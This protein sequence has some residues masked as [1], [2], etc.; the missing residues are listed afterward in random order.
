MAGAPWCQVE[1]LQAP[2][3]VQWCEQL[4]EE[5]MLV[6]YDVRGAGMSDQE[7]DDH[8]LNAQLLDLDAVI[9]ALPIPLNI[10]TELGGGNFGRWRS[11]ETAH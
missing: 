9:E 7:I 2:E 10:R 6:R 8:S 5:W 3:C 4:A 11:R 1:L